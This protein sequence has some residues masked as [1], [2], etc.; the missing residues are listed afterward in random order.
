MA[1]AAAAAL[2]CAR[3]CAEQFV[4]E[5]AL[6]YCPLVLRAGVHARP[7]PR[8]SADRPS[9][10][11]GRSSSSRLQEDVPVHLAAGLQDPP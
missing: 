6:F 3:P 5:Q 11:G 8:G 1:P 9:L 2:Y 7:S 10:R 4:A